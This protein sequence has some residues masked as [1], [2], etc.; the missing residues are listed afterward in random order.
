[1]FGHSCSI[2]TVPRRQLWLWTA[3]LRDGSA[4]L[5]HALSSTFVGIVADRWQVKNRAPAPIQ[6][7]AEQILL[8]AQERSHEAV[9]GK[10]PEQH[11]ADVEELNEYKQGKRKDFEDAIRM[12][13]QH[14]GNYIKYAAWEESQQ[15][16]ERARSV[17]ER[18]I[19]VDYQHPPLWLRYAEMEMRNKFVNRARNI[20]DRA[21]TLLPRV[22]QFW[23]KYTYMEEMVGNVKGARAVF[24][25]WMTWEPNDHAWLAFI[26]FE[27]RAGSTDRARAVYE[28]YVAAALTLT[29]YLRYARW[30]DRKQGQLAL[31][32]RIYERATEEL[33]EDEIDERLFIQFAR[34]ETRCKELDRARAIFKFSL[35]SLPKE[36]ATEL[37]KEF[38]SFEK[39][40]GDKRGVED[41]IVGK[42]RFQYEEA[43][44]KDPRNYD[45][46]FDYVRL[47]EAE[48]NADRVR[49]VYERA[50]ANVP[51]LLEKRFW[52]RYMYLWI[53]Y[54][55]YEELEARDRER[56]RAV[57][58]TALSVVP[59]GNFTFGK[60][61]LYAAKF[62]VRCHDLAAARKLLGRAI[63]MCPKENI[64][65]GYID[66]ELQLG[67]VDRCRKLYAKYLELSPHNCGAWVRFAEL[68]ESVGEEQR[69][70]AIF[71]LAVSQPA[72]DMPERL[73]KAYID[74]EIEAGQGER[75]RM[76]Y[77]RLLD[78]TKHVKVWMSYAKFEGAQ[79][80]VDAARDVFKRARD[81]LK[82]AGAPGEER[83]MLFE[84]W[85]SYERSL[86][87]NQAKIS[88]L[89][90]EAPRRV[91]KEREVYDEEGNLAGR[92]EFYDYIF[93]EDEKSR[94]Q[95]FS[96]MEKARQWQA[97]KRKADEMGDDDAP[98]GDGGDASGD[99]AGGAGGE[100]AKGGDA[101]DATSAAAGAGAG[102]GG[103][104]SD[105][106]EIDLDD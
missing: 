88:E 59:H 70:R 9:D 92:E 26:R 79:G 66:L 78:R 36:K 87:D 56:T 28:R 35:D 53:N 62:E 55:L 51:P 39:Q 85:L 80:D 31:A 63:G 101:A 16:F 15:E 30:E 103:I 44:T 41:V 74:F 83:A 61:W 105:P 60:L 81:H 3:A 52:Q 11:I 47:E 54:A 48:G 71:E 21:V 57:Y 33:P 100:E 77:E 82:D 106:H 32:R 1:M 42:R 64:I 73:W 90:A 23:L 68:E 18:A 84:A 10:A 29:A 75:A 95:L 93:P 91:K 13:R 65:K 2:N 58:R 102:S 49:E 14:L 22:D 96:F 8:E 50:V 7:T 6:I 86:P 67:E 17:Y 72:L 45:A 19:D 104:T 25:R 4:P 12:Q 46:W 20:W 37:Y 98:G 97:M 89:S 5:T 34:F 24:E 99:A 40:H 27:E 43:V 69:A 76:L 94:K 38:T